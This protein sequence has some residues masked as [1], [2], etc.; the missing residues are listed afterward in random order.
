MPRKS[1]IT[2]PKHTVK[3]FFPVEKTGDDGGWEMTWEKTPVVFR[4]NVHSMASDNL[5]RSSTTRENYYGEKPNDVYVITAPPG[6]WTAPPNSLVL[7]EPKD[8]YG[9][10][11]RKLLVQRTRVGLQRMSP[12]TMHDKI[13]CEIGNEI[14][15]DV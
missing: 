14:E 3:V 13:V 10:K 5:N 7:W 8:I 6:H 4:C 15:W 9:N 12:R 2:N 11:V 1:L